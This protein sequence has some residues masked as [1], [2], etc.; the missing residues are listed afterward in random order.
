MINLIS[1]PMSADI[2]YTKSQVPTNYVHKSNR[3]L[4]QIPSHPPGL[5]CGTR[6]L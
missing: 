3:I 1:T 6:V 4:P 5:H 2:V